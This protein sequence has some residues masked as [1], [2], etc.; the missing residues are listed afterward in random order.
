MTRQNYYKKRNR[1]H[2]LRLDETFILELVR[3]ERAIQPALGGRKLFHMLRDEFRSA[4]VFIGRDR[5]FGLLGRYNLLI[6]RRLTR[7]RTTCSNHNFRVYKNLLKDITLTG[8]NQA[9]VSDITYLPT[10]VL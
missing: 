8:P 1:R 7:P 5:F 2:Q 6:E 4:G 3:Q 9:F 10:A